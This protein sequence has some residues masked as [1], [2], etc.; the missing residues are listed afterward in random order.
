M[1]NVCIASSSN[2]R[3]GQ[4]VIVAEKFG[5]TQSDEKQLKSVLSVQ[6]FCA[7]YMLLRR[8]SEL[9]DIGRPMQSADD[10]SSKSLAECSIC[11]A[12][13][14]EMVLP[15]MHSMCTSCAEKWV[16]VKGDCPFCRK[17]YHDQK[18]LGKDQWQVGDTLSLSLS[19]STLR[20]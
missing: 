10:L 3:V 4:V 12:Q 18:R 19:L 9:M 11:R 16:K 5:D 6:D 20:A 8:Y 1:G 14:E 17:K 7:Y 2:P 13:G 15:C